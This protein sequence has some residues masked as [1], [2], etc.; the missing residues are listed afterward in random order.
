VPIYEYQCRK[1]GGVTERLEGSHDRPLSKCPSCGGKAERL[2]SPGAFILKGSGWYATDYAAKGN[3][4]GNGR[5]EKAKPSRNEVSC[6]ASADGAAPACA[7]C[8]KAE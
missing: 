8:P 5:G 2:M 7:G 4:N 1:C 3:G 6:P